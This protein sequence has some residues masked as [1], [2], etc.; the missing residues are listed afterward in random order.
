MI[1]ICTLVCYLEYK[2]VNCLK[3]IRMCYDHY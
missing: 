2:E 3:A 1:D